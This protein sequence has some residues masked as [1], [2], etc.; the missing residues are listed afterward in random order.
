MLRNGAHSLHNRQ[1]Q[2]LT[3][4]MGTLRQQSQRKVTHSILNL[5]TLRVCVCVC[6]CL[7]IH[8]SEVLAFMFAAHPIDVPTALRCVCAVERAARVMMTISQQCLPSAFGGC[9]LLYVVCMHIAA[10]TAGLL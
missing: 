1:F 6:V 9:P 8:A 7:P 2:L 3:I 10:C 4:N 5:S